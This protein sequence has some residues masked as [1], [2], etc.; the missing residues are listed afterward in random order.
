MDYEARLRSL[1][2][3]MEIM[4]DL[5]QRTLDQLTYARQTISEALE[6][7]MTYK[8]MSGQA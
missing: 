5:A 8:M 3:D 2:V 1:D 6:E 4:V 7:E